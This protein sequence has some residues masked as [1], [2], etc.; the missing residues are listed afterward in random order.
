MVRAIKVESKKTGG[1]WVVTRKLL[2]RT[3]HKEMKAEGLNHQQMLEF[4]NELLG[5]VNVD[6]GEEGR[7]AS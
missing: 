2:A 4:A 7:K 5:L 1:G 3:L 6:M